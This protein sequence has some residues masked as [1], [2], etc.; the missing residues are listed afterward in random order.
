MINPLRLRLLTHLESLGTVRAVADALGLSPSSVSQQLSVLE[1]EARTR[2][3]EHHGRRVRLTQAGVL[4][5]EHGREIL[6]RIEAAEAELARRSDGP[7]GTVRVAGFASGLH[8]IVLPAAGALRAAHPDL[9][10][11]PVEL[12]A[13]AGLAALRRGDADI[14]VI[15]DFD[16]GWLPVDPQLRTIPLASDR[17]VLVTAAGREPVRLTDLAGEPWALDPPGSYQ[18]QLVTRLCRQAGFEPITGGAYASYPLLLQQV[19]A[20][21]AVSLLPELAVDPRFALTTH[22]PDPGDDPAHHGRR[23]RHPAAARDPGRPGRAGGPGR[24]VSRVGR[25]PPR[26][27]P[28]RGPARRGSWRPPCSCAA[29]PP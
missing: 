22:P 27:S 29:P 6:R 15:F 1:R 21:L 4:L 25:A 7:V 16:D 17:L 9:R 5:A 10:V 12:D 3:L 24:A 11:V 14:A 13:H 8:T 26:P 19:E 23:A 28:P 18:V 20:G 2:L